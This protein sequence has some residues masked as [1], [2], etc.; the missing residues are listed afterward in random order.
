MSTKAQSQDALNRRSV[1]IQWLVAIW[2]ILRNDIFT[3]ILLL[4]SFVVFV[5]PDQC[6]DVFNMICLQ[7]FGKGIFYPTYFFNIHFL[8][9]SVATVLWAYVTYMGSRLVLQIS[10][11]DIIKSTA[12]SFLVRWAPKAF[13]VAPFFIIAIAFGFTNNYES[14]H[15]IKWWYVGFFVIYGICF[16]LSIHLFEKA[17]AQERQK[18]PDKNVFPVIQWNTS[19]N[20]SQ[21]WEFKSY[22]EELKRDWEKLRNYSTPWI[23]IRIN[24]I[25]FM[26]LLIT[27]VLIPSSIW[28][29]YHPANLLGTA[30]IGA[31]G[32]AFLQLMSSVIVYFND[33]RNR[34]IIQ[35]FFILIMLFSLTNDN[36]DIRTVGKFEE[37]KRPTIAD[38]F[39]KWLQ[40]RARNVDTV[41][42]PIPVI[43]IATEGGGIRAAHWTI[44]A[45]ENLNRR[46]LGFN[47]YTYAISGVSGGGVGAAM[48]LAHKRDL[49]IDSLPE[50]DKIITQEF[51]NYINEDFLASVTS[52]LFFSDMINSFQPLPFFKSLN[53]TRRL[54]DAWGY[55]YEHHIHKK[56]F[57]EPFLSLWQNETGGYNYDLPSLFLN[58]TLADNGSRIITTNLQLSTLENVDSS[59][60]F[61]NIYDLLNMIKKD[62][63]LKTAASLCSRFPLVTNGGKFF[64][65]DK[66]QSGYITDGGYFENTG[67][68]TCLAILNVITEKAKKKGI[69]IAPY[70]LFL[71][72][73]AID[74]DTVKAHT[75]FRSVGTITNSFINSWSRGSQTRNGIYKRLIPRLDKPQ[76]EYLHLPLERRN[77]KLET[78]PLGWVLSSIA[79]KTIKQRAD[80]LIFFK[81]S[82]LDKKLV[83][84]DS[85][86]K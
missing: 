21:F 53:R 77:S 22:R 28:G 16:L 23:F 50:R 44:Q 67:V 3:P 27:L 43:L 18:Y 17:E 35:I 5:V 54:E 37:D 7:N 6:T 76:V 40:I 12:S 56:T 82:P 32:F 1:F 85:L 41:N 86:I 61:E 79:S 9:V 84:L 59:A 75:F 49:S 64:S 8:S 74:T 70:I 69:K 30:A 24:L 36:S 60:Q 83:Q 4:L 51:Q 11:I 80:T 34:P 78:L 15:Y 71:Q 47:H 58:G 81:G 2:Q 72:N 57:H 42:K 14:T 68:E 55:G 13:G 73:S 39:D 10:P 45:L 26:L 25:A 62:I 63:P 38:H 20:Q 19:P 66:K 52:G 65:A 48:Y 31:F 29:Y 46:I 33:Y